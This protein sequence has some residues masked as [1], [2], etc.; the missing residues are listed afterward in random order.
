MYVSSIVAIV[1]F[2]LQFAQNLILINIGIIYNC[3][4]EKLVHY[5]E[6]TKCLSALEPFLGCSRWE[7]QFHCRVILSSVIQSKGKI[8]VVLAKLSED[9]LKTLFK[10][11]DTIAHSSER[12]AS[13]ENCKFSVSEL[14]ACVNLLL[15]NPDNLL[16]FAANIDFISLLPGFLASSDAVEQKV[17]L[18]I[19]WKVLLG[20]L[21]VKEV[22]DNYYSVISDAV[23]K[24][25]KADD[26]SDL[27][28]LSKCV[29]FVI[30]SGTS[31]G[32][33][34]NFSLCNCERLLFARKFGTHII[35]ISLD[36][37]DKLWLNLCLI[38]L[39]M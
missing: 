6:G 33:Y 31:A 8:E 30:A 23:L 24:L 22:L 12:S 15:V 32:M 2:P 35:V 3:K 11:L 25:V 4:E 14:L 9:E 18:E 38:K 19:L 21:D 10:L 39:S 26:S 20:P 27:F 17:T 34:L 16:A 37:F 28:M 29:L 5:F 7:L 13:I 1:F 36:F